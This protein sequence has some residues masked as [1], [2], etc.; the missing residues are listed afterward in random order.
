[1]NAIKKMIA[2]Q[3]ARI[4]K[5]EIIAALEREKTKISKEETEHYLNFLNT[6]TMVN[7]NRAK[8]I[9]IERGISIVNQAFLAFESNTK[10]KKSNT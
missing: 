10:T 5:G 9:G 3:A 4:V 2:M 1:M 8:T 7:L 6:G